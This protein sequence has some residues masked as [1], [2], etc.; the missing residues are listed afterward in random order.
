M[1]LNTRRRHL[2]LGTVAVNLAVKD[3]SGREVDLAA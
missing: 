3:A 2:L 1:H